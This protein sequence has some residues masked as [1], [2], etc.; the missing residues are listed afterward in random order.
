MTMVDVRVDHRLIEQTLETMSRYVYIGDL[1][2]SQRA[3]IEELQRIARAATV[4]RTVTDESVMV[5]A[6]CGVR[7]DAC[8]ECGHTETERPTTVDADALAEALSAPADFVVT[9]CDS[10]EDQ[11]DA[12]CMCPRCFANRE[13]QV[14][15]RRAAQRAR[16]EA[17]QRTTCRCC[18]D[19]V[20]TVT[21]LA[22]HITRHADYC[23]L[24]GWWNPELNAD[25]AASNM[26]SHW[27]AEHPHCDEC[28]LFFRSGDTFDTH[29]QQLHGIDRLADATDRLLATLRAPRVPEPE[30]EVSVDGIDIADPEELAA[31]RLRAMARQ[32]AHSR[33]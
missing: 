33:R 5:C 30:G 16:R 8:P 15:A 19:I 26:R 21:D 1:R 7:R 28:D 23:G 20:P 27:N 12:R 3:P 18:G 9:E 25:R 10:P 13:R 29:R 4:E 2:M 22:R 6:G 31:P 24:C 11:P 17:Q 14:Q 32:L